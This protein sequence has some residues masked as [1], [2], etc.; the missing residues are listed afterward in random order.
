MPK[1]VVACE[2][3]TAGDG[4]AERERAQVSIAQALLQRL[5]LS[6][7]VR[8]L[9]IGTIPRIERGKARRVAERSSASDPLPG[10]P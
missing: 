2:L 9:P 8:V 7:E 5:G 10:L 6:T 3:T 4:A 1:L